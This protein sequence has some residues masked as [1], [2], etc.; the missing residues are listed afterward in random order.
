M[1]KKWLAFLGV[2]LIV[3][4][5][6]VF[7]GVCIA[8]RFDLDKLDATEYRRD[9]IT[10][11]DSFTNI[12]F[13]VD[14]SDLALK[15]SDDGSCRV[16]I[17]ETDKITHS[18][19]VDHDTLVIRSE[20]NRKWYDN[21][22]F[23]LKSPVITVYLPA[24]TYDTLH[25]DGSTSDVTVPAGFSFANVDIDLSTGDLKFESNVTGTLSI[26]TSTGDVALDGCK[27][28]ELTIKTSTGDVSLADISCPRTTIRTSTG[29]VNGTLRTPVT[30][31]AKS[32]TGD[33]SI[34]KE[35]G[36]GTCDIVTSTG[37]IDIRFKND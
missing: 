7:L 4:G 24:D 26:K 16:E 34:P 18:V 14:V 2:F 29:E 9:T 8:A 10:V 6:G 25:A 13:E 23:F 28:S 21:F 5:C 27:A 36:D 1:N 32:S 12:D 33:I 11:T 17:L 30:V 37:D 35:T 31:T 3:A 22:G 15:R 20:E 19:T